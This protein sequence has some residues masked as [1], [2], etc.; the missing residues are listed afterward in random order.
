[1]WLLFHHSPPP[2]LLLQFGKRSLCLFCG[3]R[4]GFCNGILKLAL[5]INVYFIVSEQFFSMLELTMFFSSF[6]ESSAALV[7]L[8]CLI[9]T[10]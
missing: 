8:Y 5:S 2:R 3:L 6:A 7:S 9:R 4:C 10:G 1:M